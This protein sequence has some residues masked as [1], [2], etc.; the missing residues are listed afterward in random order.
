MPGC[1]KYYNCLLKPNF[2]VEK[3]TKQSLVKLN[4]RPR[5]L[6]LEGNMKF[7]AV[8]SHPHAYGKVQPREVER[9]FHF[10]TAY[11]GRGKILS[12]NS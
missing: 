11:Q 3:A 2:S 9:F 6:E 5:T 7:L 4:H 1:I 12:D 8:Y 10:H